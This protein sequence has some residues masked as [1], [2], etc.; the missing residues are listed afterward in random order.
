MQPLA[1]VLALALAASAPA[2]AQ[3][4]VAA[5]YSEP[6][7]RYGHGILGDAIEWGALDL[8]LSD[9]TRVTLRL[10]QTRVFEDTAPR[11]ADLDGDGAA[12]V[13]VVETDMAQGASLA[14]YGSA[15]K[16]AATPYIGRSNRWLAPLGS[17][18]LDGDGHVELAYIDRPHLAKTLR[19]WRYRDGQLTHVADL[20]GLTNHR[21]GERD[22]AGGIR[23]CGQGPEI[24]TADAGWSRLIASQLGAGGGITSRDIGPHEGRASFATALGCN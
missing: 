4:I 7:D 20:A 8:T 16:I 13:V 24:I 10:P 12:E 2:T 3:Q 9:G 18:D 11:L 1:V 15:G 19:I 5:D 17:A 6:T 14:V 22:I 21:I 23:D